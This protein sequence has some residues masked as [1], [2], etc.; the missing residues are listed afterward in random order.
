MIFRLFGLVGMVAMALSFIACSD[1][2]TTTSSSTLASNV[3]GTYSGYT[4]GSCDD[5]T[6]WVCIDESITVSSA[7]ETTVDVSY[8]SD[9]WGT[10][11]I[12]DAIVSECDSSY[13][14][15]GSGTAEIVID[16]D[17]CTYAVSVDAVI[18]SDGE[19]TSWIFNAPSSL[20]GYLT[21]EFVEGDATV[22]SIVAATYKGYTQAATPH[23]TNLITADETVTVSVSTETTVN[24]SYESDTWGTFTIEDATVT[25]NDTD[26]LYY[27]NGSG[28]AE[29][30]TDMVSGTYD[31]NVEAVVD[32][33]KNIKS[34]MFGL[35]S[36]M[37]SLIINF[38]E[39]EA[40]ATDD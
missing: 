29:M 6:D 10:F 22:S 5:Y 13:V 19:V 32:S 40:P 11:T 14:I 18:D 38:I 7:S 3:T 4:I 21:I 15:S 25:L 8:E 35:P 12:E 31:V 16:T 2:D 9:K 27:I 23:F 34:W 33:D 17:T 24:I 26:G 37:Q 39:G 30:D 28:T 36:V 1:D 20:W